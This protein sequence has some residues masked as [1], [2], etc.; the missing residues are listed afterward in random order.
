MI[1]ILERGSISLSQAKATR[2]RLLYSISFSKIWRRSLV[3]SETARRRKRIYTWSQSMPSCFSYSP[4]FFS[5]FP[6]NEKCPTPKLSSPSTPHSLKHYE[7]Q[8]D[9]VSERG[10]P[11]DLRFPGQTKCFAM[12]CLRPPAIRTPTG[13]WHHRFTPESN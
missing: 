4:P 2:V 8:T 3:S 11:K 5:R 12:R 1:Y 10:Q 13:Q 7:N 6:C 9:H